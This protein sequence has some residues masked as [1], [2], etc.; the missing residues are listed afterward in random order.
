[1]KITSVR[2]TAEQ[3][4]ALERLAPALTLQ[5]PDLAALAGGGGLSV[6]A[7][8]RIAVTH[9]IRLLEA[10]VAAGVPAVAPPKAE[11]GDE[12]ADQDTVKIR[13]RNADESGG[14]AVATPPKKGG[15][16]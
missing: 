12:A 5:R 7:V 4:A 3:E 15:K 8:L 14:V 16:P 9:G 2:L 13:Y 10:E 11:G 6:Y 1:M